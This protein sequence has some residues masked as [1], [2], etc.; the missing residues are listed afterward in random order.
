MRKSLQGCA[1]LG[2]CVLL[3]ARAPLLPSKTE[4]FLSFLH[5]GT[6]IAALNSLKMSA[7][8][9]TSLKVL[10][11]PAHIASLVGRAIPGCGLDF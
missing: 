8:G 6:L 9:T 4:N 1:I 7:I 11:T 5:S 3:N 10:D 2:G